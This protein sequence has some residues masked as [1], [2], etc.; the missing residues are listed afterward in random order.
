MPL[1]HQTANQAF[2]EDLTKWIFQETGVVKV[3]GSTHYGKG[4]ELEKEQY[5]KNEQVVSRCC[6]PEGSPL[7]RSV[8]G[9]MAC[10]RANP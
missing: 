2:A 4:G 6:R 8:L 5:T 3:V 10:K 7:L 9:A 1:R